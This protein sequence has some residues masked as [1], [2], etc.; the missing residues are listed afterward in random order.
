M[1]A[2][3]FLCAGV[4][5][6]FPKREQNTTCRPT[7]TSALIPVQLLDRTAI[8][9][10]ARYPH[11][12]TDLQ[13]TTPPRKSKGVSCSVTGR[14]RCD[15]RRK[16]DD[17]GVQH[18]G[19][20]PV[21]SAGPVPVPVPSPGPCPC[22]LPFPN[23]SKEPCGNTSDADT[24]APLS[25]HDDAAMLVRGIAATAIV[26]TAHRVTIPAAFFMRNSQG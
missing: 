7:F 2:K 1:G 26:N 16:R 9:R 11:L 5:E 3:L 14:S 8:L 4:K 10:H 23:R 6:K 13:N 17:H 20:Y 24:T 15:G 12:L 25:P 22:P 19:P 18:P 21:P